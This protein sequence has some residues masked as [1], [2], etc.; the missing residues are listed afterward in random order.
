MD[1]RLEIITR[2]TEEIVTED[3]LR[4]LLTMKSEPVCYCGY[5]TSG[6][7]HLGHLVT[8]SKLKDMEKAGFK[9]KALPGALGKREMT[10]GLK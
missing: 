10:R 1:D 3:E 6:D 4:N 5:E 7:V 2:N 9:V 8:M